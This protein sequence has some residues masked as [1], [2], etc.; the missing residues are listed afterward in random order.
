MFDLSQLE[1]ALITFN[2]DKCLKNT[3]DRVLGE[4]SPVRSCPIV[5]V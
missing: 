1:I 2:R 3:L 4:D 5:V